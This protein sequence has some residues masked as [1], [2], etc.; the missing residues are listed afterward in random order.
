M[1]TQAG[2]NERGDKTTS[3]KLKK[4]MI[5][6]MVTDNDDNERIETESNQ[7]PNR[8]LKAISLL[9]VLCKTYKKDSVFAQSLL[10]ILF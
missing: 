8:C 4:K 1:I 2:T 3:E 9:Q 10:N 5:T 6:V 7:V